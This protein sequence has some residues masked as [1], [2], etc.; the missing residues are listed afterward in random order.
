MNTK[1]VKLQADL[2]E[3][4]E[5]NKCLSSNQEIYQ[6]KLL[7][8]EESLNKSNKE[9]EKEIQ[10][11][12]AQLRDIMF[13]LDA[14]AKF[15]ESKDVTK[16]ELQDSQL[17]INQSESSASAMNDSTTSKGRRKKKK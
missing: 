16:E 13:Y 9:K 17:I 6:K 2:N 8:L 5:L 12:Q 14:Q 15:D 7:S 4:K 1:V 11:L 10:D 3:E